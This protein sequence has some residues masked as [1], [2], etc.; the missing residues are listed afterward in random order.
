VKEKTVLVGAHV[1]IA[2]GLHKAVERALA[3]GA[4][5]MQIFTKSSRSWYDKPISP[6]TEKLFKKA[7][8]DSG[9]KKIVAHASYLI[10]IASA[11][12]NTEQ[13]S[14]AALKH[15]LHRCEQL[16][17]PFLVLHPGSHIGDG[18]EKGIKKICKN[19]DKVL[20]TANGKT[21]LLLETMA[22]QG[23]NLGYT[24]KQ[25][26]EIHDR[27]THKKHLGVCLDT[28]HIFAAGY[29]L[30]N[31]TEYEKTMKKFARIVGLRKLKAIHLNDSKTELGS[32]KDRHESLGKGQIPK[33]IFQL[34]MQDKRLVGIPKILETPDPTLYKEEISLL[35]RWA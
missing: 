19:L 21:K 4:T 2:G 25:I 26:R 18:E 20:A 24:F 23:T 11:K 33:K 35:K 3:L 12:P 32:R 5:T 7:L 10:N 27:C 6:E 13:Q 17:I 16:S 8:K 15:E 28:C 31:T 14:V 22:G 9:L 34:I 30:R 1:S 29:E